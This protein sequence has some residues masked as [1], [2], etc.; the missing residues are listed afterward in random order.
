MKKV[1]GLLCIVIFMSGC[2]AELPLIRFEDYTYYYRYQPYQS[3]PAYQNRVY[4]KYQP[5][6]EY[7][8]KRR[9]R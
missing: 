1:I 6:Y 2:Y 7:S 8:R 3:R 9:H 4:Q 5:R